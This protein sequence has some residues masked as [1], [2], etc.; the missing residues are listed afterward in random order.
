MDPEELRKQIKKWAL[1]AAFFVL[2]LVFYV[3][4]WAT[5][6]VAYVI[7]VGLVAVLAILIQSGRGGGLSASLA[8]LGGDALLSARSATPIAKATYVMLALFIFLTLLIA[9]MEPAGEEPAGLVPAPEQPA[10]ALPLEG[11]PVG[12]PA[13]PP[14]TPAEAPAPAGDTAP[15]EPVT[16]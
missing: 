9:R 5:L 14:E 3:L 13:A 10:P 7:A 6:L 11:G 12:E 4:Q 8:G 16:Q 2:A 15:A 1:I